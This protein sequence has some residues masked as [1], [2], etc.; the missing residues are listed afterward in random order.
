MTWHWHRTQLIAKKR[1]PKRAVAHV[2]KVKGTQCKHPVK[3]Q[4]RMGAEAGIPA[5]TVSSCGVI[6]CPPGGEIDLTDLAKSVSR[7]W[8]ENNFDGGTVPPGHKVYIGSCISLWAAGSHE[9]LGH[10]FANP[11]IHGGPR[12]GS[13]DK[14]CL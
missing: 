10:A 8:E 6:F 12:C 9:N 11:D 3:E 14:V 13:V 7:Y 2:N 4:L 1:R 5:P